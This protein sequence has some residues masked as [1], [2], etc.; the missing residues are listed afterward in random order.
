MSSTR[1]SFHAP[2]LSRGVVERSIHELHLNA[3]VRARTMRVCAHPHTRASCHA[4]TLTSQRTEVWSWRVEN[5]TVSVLYLF[6]TD[7]WK[8]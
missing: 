3:C 2:E 7:R 8:S 1:F 5:I 6:S 4:V